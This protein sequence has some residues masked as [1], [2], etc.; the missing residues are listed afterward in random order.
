MALP[1]VPESVTVSPLF[2]LFKD[3]IPGTFVMP[4]FDDDT[5]A[6]ETQVF[7]GNQ[8]CAADVCL[9]TRCNADV[10]NRRTDGAETFAWMVPCS[11]SSCVVLLLPMV[12]PIPPVPIRPLFIVSLKRQDE[13]VLVAAMISTLLPAPSTTV[14]SALDCVP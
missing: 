11:R 6:D 2:F 3:F 7:P 10:A 13:L 1:T 14:L 9:F 4:R 8:V 12:K 5:I